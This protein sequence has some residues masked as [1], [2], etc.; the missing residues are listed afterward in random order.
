MAFQKGACMTNE[1]AISRRSLLKKSAGSAIGIGLLG[2][3]GTVLAARSRLS[4]QG[5]GLPTDGVNYLIKANGEYFAGVVGGGKD[6]HK[7]I[8]VEEGHIEYIQA[9]PVGEADGGVLHFE[10]NLPDEVNGEVGISATGNFAHV[11]N[12]T[13]DGEADYMGSADCTLPGTWCQDGIEGDGLSNAPDVI[14]GSVGADY[15]NYSVNGSIENITT[16]GYME[17]SVE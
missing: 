6:K 5:E 10:S 13:V 2:S 14:S 4:V 11:Y 7:E 12:I 17:V 8:D 15:D 3:A 9:D 1:N 16:T